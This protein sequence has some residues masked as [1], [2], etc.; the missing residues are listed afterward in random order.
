MENLSTFTKE[1]NKQITETKYDKFL[2]A[3]PF[4]CYDDIGKWQET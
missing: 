3:I 2:Q 4:L 1:A